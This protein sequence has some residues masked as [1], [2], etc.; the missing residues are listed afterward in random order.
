MK[1]L[2]IL[3]AETI[4]LALQDEILRSDEARH[5]HWLRGVLRVV[6]GMS[7][8]EV[9]RLLSDTTQTVQYWVHRFEADGLAGLAQEDRPGR[10]ARLGVAQLTEI[11]REPLWRWADGQSLGWQDVGDFHCA[12]L[13]NGKWC[14]LV[15]TAVPETG[16][17]PVQTPPGDRQ[18]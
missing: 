1:A 4:C 7:C 14:T 5:D 17:S 16:F 11:S 2:M 9:G 13:G 6:Q 12:T 3:D 10:P 18:D 8:P 15:S